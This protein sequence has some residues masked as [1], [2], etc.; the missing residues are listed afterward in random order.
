MAHANTFAEACKET[1]VSSGFTVL[2]AKTINSAVEDVA[3]LA[4]RVLVNMGLTGKD[5]VSSK[6][7]PH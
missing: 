1:M 3:V 7:N 6:Y 5:I 4:L 2:A